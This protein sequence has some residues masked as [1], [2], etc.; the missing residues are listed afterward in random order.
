VLLNKVQAQT[1]T[2]GQPTIVKQ[3][4]E[5]KEV[6]AGGEGYLLESP[7]MSPDGIL[8]FTDITFTHI[9]GMKAGIIWSFNLQT[10]QSKVVRSP[11]GMANGLIFDTEGNLI[12]CEGADYQRKCSTGYLDTPTYAAKML[13]LLVLKEVLSCQLNPW[14]PHL[15]NDL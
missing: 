2:Q 4:A 10:R 14:S 15:L 3:H 12:V 5:V 6:F 7:N 1:N 8:Y 13:L 11:S 9:A